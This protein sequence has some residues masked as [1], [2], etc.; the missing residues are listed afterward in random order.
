VVTA[1]AELRSPDS[2][3]LLDTAAVDLRDVT[4]TFATPNGPLRAVDR[5]SLC[6]VAGA[7]HGIIGLS[8]AGKSTLLRI[9]N[10]LERPD[11]GEVVVG[12][13]DLAQLRDAEVREAR[14]GIGMIFQ[15]FNLLNNLTVYENVA[16]PLEISGVA[17]KDRR[18]IVEDRLATVGLTDKLRAYPAKL[19][20]GQKQRVAIARALATQPRLLLCDEPTSSVDPETKGTILGYLREVN[21]RFGISIV[22]VTH[23]MS[24][25]RAVCD[26]VTVLERGRVIEEFAPN[27]A[28]HQPRSGIAKFLARTEI[29]LDRTEVPE[30]ALAVG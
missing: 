23:E 8:G 27:D 10:L 2:R 13:R 9:I 30:E 17:A 6:V 15:H 22:I 19:S 20:G 7:I 18:A 11:G 16:L 5:V 3:V 21:R 28:R 14:R 25:I 4:K 26:V 1:A 29:V 12:G 24:V